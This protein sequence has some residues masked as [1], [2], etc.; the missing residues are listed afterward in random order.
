MISFDEA[1]DIILGLPF[2]TRTETVPFLSAGGRY[3]AGPVE[4]TWSL[5]RFDNSAMDGFALRSGDIATAS[6]EHPSRLAIA[7]ES[8]AGSPFASDCPS[9]S[10]IRISTGAR[11]PAGLDCVVPI[12]KVRVENGEVL[13][14]KSSAPGAHV[15][16]E[17]EDVARG[18]Q[19]FRRGTRLHPAALSFLAMYNLPDVEVVVPPRVGILTSG[20]EI[21]RHGETLRETD[22]VGVNIYHLEHELRALGCEPRIFGIASDTAESF[23]RLLLE[24][25][26]WSDVVVSTAGVSVGE[27]D[28]VGAV[29]RDL[30][31]N[32]HF[33][34]VAVRPGKPMLVATI[35]GKH[36][37]ALPG[38]PVAVCCNTEVF[39][40]P[41][42][43]QAF[44]I[45]PVLAPAEKMTL[46]SECPRD[47]ARLFFVYGEHSLRDGRAVV[48]PFGRQSSGNLHNPAL[49]N[50]L[51]RVGPGPDPL[52]PGGTVDVFRLV[53]GT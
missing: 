32:V 15:R 38:N 2:D 49:A 29:L 23:R 34:K 7:G 20:D 33:W 40:K 17:G 6:D 21:R 11:V 9:G 25:L 37:F 4:A 43:R 53:P 24:A 14:R 12:E 13:L 5:P 30:D 41:F 35:A 22:V 31:A 52:V 42:F 36:Y 51:I 19:L 50:A 39:L 26:E 3:L 27:H 10:A 18:T 47:R 8:A 46:L 45:E 16:R 48:R 44:G 1:L 28:V